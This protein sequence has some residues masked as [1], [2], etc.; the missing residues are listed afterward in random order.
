MDRAA[1]E[2]LLG[3]VA[4]GRTPAAEAAVRLAR[5]PYADLGVARVDHHRSLRQ[6]MPEAVYG[7]GKSPAHCVAIVSE[8]LGHGDGPVV[9]TRCDEAQRSAVLNAHPGALCTG[10]TLVWRAATP[11]DAAAVVLTAGTADLPVAEECAAVLSA[12]GIA[13]K[14][15]AD[16]GVA[17]I[18]RLLDHLDDLTGADA[19]VVVAGMEGALASV[20]AGLVAAPV[21]AVPTSVGY[22]SALEGITALLAMTSSCAPGVTVVGI[23][24][25]YGAAC[26]AAR[27]LR[28]R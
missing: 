16:C 13:A 18:H 10:R 26:A 12:F 28:S 14:L 19:I 5:L 3:D 4:A 8:L 6:G 20:V 15:I 9:L 22:G 21:V 24:N 2:S 7:P 1:L 23:D 17:G 27:A 25:G 11:R